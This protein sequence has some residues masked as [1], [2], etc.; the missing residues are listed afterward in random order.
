MA[1]STL[2]DRRVAAS[3]SGRA[4]LWIRLADQFANVALF[5]DRLAVAVDPCWFFEKYRLIAQATEDER[6]HR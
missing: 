6:C 1:I 4:L 3:R 2:G 5:V